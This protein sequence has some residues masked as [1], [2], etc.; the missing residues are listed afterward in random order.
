M[1]LALDFFARDA[2]IVAAELIGKHL[3]HGAH[4]G[5]IVEVEAYLGPRD[6]ASHARFGPHGR[7]RLLYGP[8]GIAYVYL[9]YGMHECFNVVTGV[10]GEAS[11]VLIRALEPDQG[12][13]RCDGPGRLTRALGI[14]RRHNGLDLTV[15][16][17]PGEALFIEDRHE[18]RPRITTTARI[19][20]DY[21]GSWARRRLRYVD[22]RSTGLSVRLP[23]TPRF[24]RARAAR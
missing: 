8:P 24:A 19:G 5:R 23:G 11:A 17:P 1:R 4:G 18:A 14:D 13:P 15:P 3:R 12:L 16:A 10:D 20:V 6:L 9:I 21:A 22:A 7:A 2:Q